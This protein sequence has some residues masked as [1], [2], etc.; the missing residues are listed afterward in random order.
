MSFNR[1][2]ICVQAKNRLSILKARTGLTP[3]ILCRIGLCL[4]LREPAIPNPQRYD[5]NGQ[6]FNRYTLLGEMDAFFIAL[7][8]ERLLQDGLDPEEDFVS[9]FRA[10]LNRGAI[11]I[12]AKVKHLGDLYELLPSRQ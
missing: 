5:E 6:E 3:N 12:F 1:I 7:M 4:S 8:K 10:H 2:R 9:Q 11:S